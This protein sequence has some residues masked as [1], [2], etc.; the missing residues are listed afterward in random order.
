MITKGTARIK[1]YKKYF[2]HSVQEQE[3]INTVSHMAHLWRVI[4]QHDVTVTGQFQ[5]TSFAMLRMDCRSV[6]NI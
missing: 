1:I 6:T 2:L 5:T 3:N 4:E